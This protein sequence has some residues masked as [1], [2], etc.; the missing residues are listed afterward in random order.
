MEGHARAGPRASQPSQSS[1]RGVPLYKVNC[2][3]ICQFLEITIE[4]KQGDIDLDA[5]IDHNDPSTTVC[6]SELS[7]PPETFDGAI[8]TFNTDFFFIMPK[9]I[10]SVGPAEVAILSVFARK[11]VVDPAPRLIDQLL[12]VEVINC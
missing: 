9:R 10:N 6:N 8:S 12:M 7:A 2:D 11:I 5:R 3:G 1:T 4:S